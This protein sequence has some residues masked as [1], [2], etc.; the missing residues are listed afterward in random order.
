MGFFSKKVFKNNNENT[1]EQ[2]AQKRVNEDGSEWMQKAYETSKSFNN[3]D[4][5]GQDAPKR[6]R[7][8][9]A[10]EDNKENTF[11]TASIVATNKSLLLNSLVKAAQQDEFAETLILAAAAKIRVLKR[12]EED[13]KLPKEL[14]DILKTL[15]ENL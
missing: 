13:E 12:I 7:L 4:M 9:I 2:E 10:A 5:G 6:A 1:S 14:K 15:M 8:Y 11:L 3:E